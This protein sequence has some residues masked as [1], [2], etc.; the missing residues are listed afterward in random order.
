V[1]GWGEARTGNQ[2]TEN[3]GAEKKGE[4]THSVGI[5]VRKKFVLASHRKVG[6]NY[7]GTLVVRWWGRGGVRCGLI[8]V[9]KTQRENE[10][11]FMQGAEI[12]KHRSIRFQKNRCKAS[13]EKGS[14]LKRRRKNR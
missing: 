13:A 7:R 9:G 6:Q 4:K 11:D 12:R 5:K 10:E 1:Q 3:T 2:F 8:G 14:A